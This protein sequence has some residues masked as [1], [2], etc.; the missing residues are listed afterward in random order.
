MI[1]LLAAHL[2]KNIFVNS[3]GRIV[4]SANV[5]NVLGAPTMPFDWGAYPGASVS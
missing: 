5:T 2:T 1:V 4:P 3:L